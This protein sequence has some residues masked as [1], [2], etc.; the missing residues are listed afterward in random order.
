MVAAMR[1][2]T[3]IKAD[4]F[5]LRSKSI[6][7][8]CHVPTMELWEEAGRRIRSTGEVPPR[9][10]W[11]DNESTW[12]YM[13]VVKDMIMRGERPEREFTIDLVMLGS[14]WGL[15]TMPGEVFSEYEVWINA[16]A[17]FDHNMVFAFTNAFVGATDDDYIGYVP[18]DRALSL[19]IKTPI[20]AETACMEAGSFPG[21]FHGV[22]VEGAYTCY[23][24]GVE[25]MIKEA[26]ASLWAQ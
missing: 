26:I 21:F 25:G 12:K 24:V 13:E 17:P 23:A 15:V 18:T 22:R 8:P 16:F 9:E 19:G 3:E 5:I 11:G 4:K 14:E 1:E 7:L 2:T 20:V 6:M 10:G